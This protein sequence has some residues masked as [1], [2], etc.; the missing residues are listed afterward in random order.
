[1]FVTSESVSNGHPDK[2][3]DAIADAILDE[4]LR[5]DRYARVACECF[6]KSDTVI[7]GGEISSFATV[8]I[9]KVVRRVIQ[10]IGYNHKETGFDASTCSILTFITQ[11][12]KDISKG[13]RDYKNLGAGDQGIMYGYATNETSQFMPTSIYYANKLMYRHRE[14]RNNYSWICPDAKAQVSVEYLDG[15]AIGINS[16]VLSTQHSKDAKIDDVRE[17]VMENIIK[18]VIPSEMLSDTKIFINPIGLFTVGGPIADSGLTG[19]KLMVDTYGGVARHG[20]GSFSGKDPSKVD[21]TGA[22]LARYIAKNLVAAKLLPKCEVQVSYMIGEAM[23]LN[24]D[25][26]TFGYNKIDKLEIIDLVYNNFNFSLNNI[27]SKFDMLKPIYQNL[28]S[29]GHFGRSDCNVGWEDIIILSK[30]GL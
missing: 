8:D 29:Y 10:N 24:I 6:I 1:M 27:V 18:Q 4:Y 7:I 25:I 17:L 13:I 23:P 11:Q 15:K 14:V 19:R 5:Y 16:I 20:G 12:S 9:E 21:R 26:N 30:L 3:A 28:S 2:I 22:Y